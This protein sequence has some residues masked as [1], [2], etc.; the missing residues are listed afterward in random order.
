MKK[1]VELLIQ[2]NLIENI[3]DIFYLK[4]ENLSNLNRMGEKS[5]ANIIKSIGHL[6]IFI[7]FNK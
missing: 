3:D 5:A 7:S 4:S 2:N 6:S 1:I